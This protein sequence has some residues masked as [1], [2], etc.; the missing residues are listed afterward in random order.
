MKSATQVKTF[1]WKL[2]W[3]K[4]GWGWKQGGGTKRSAL[5]VDWRGGESRP[6]EHELF[7]L[8][9]SPIHW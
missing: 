4:T 3:D 2:T 6:A 5:V 9:R 1:T 7:W 8:S